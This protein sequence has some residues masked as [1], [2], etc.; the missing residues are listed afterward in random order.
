MV[1]D[2]DVSQFLIAGTNS[3]S[4]KTTLTLGIL[5]ALSRRGMRVAPFKCGPDYID[6]LFHKQAAGRDSLNLDL[7]FHSESCYAPAL[8]DAD[9]AVVEGVMGLFDGVSP[10]RIDGSCAEV[11][12]CLNLP[13]ILTVNA[14]GMSGSIAPLVKGFS[15]WHPKL[16]IAGVIANQVGSPRH[17]ELLK[18]SLREAGLPPLMG[19]LLRDERWTLPERHLGLTVHELSDD[20]LNLL[21]DTLESSLDL[22]QLLSLCRVT[23]PAAN[24]PAFPPARLRLGVAGDEAFCFY[25]RSNLDAL[26]R[27][28]VEPVF[29]SPLHDT[30]L[31]PG[32]H[33]LYL[34][35]GYPEL[36]LDELAAN[37]TMVNSIKA[38]AQHHLVYGECGGYLSLLDEIR[39]FSGILHPGLGL[40]PGRARMNRKLSALGYRTVSGDWGVVRG[41]EFHYSSL[42][43]PLSPPCLWT[44][45]DLRGNRIPCGGIRGRVRGSYVHLFFDS[46]NDFLSHFCRELQS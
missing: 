1:S 21:A 19:F 37:R 9:V 46:G 6:P 31:P 41:H 17:G 28:G 36:F 16:K 34:G 7:F 29:F 43:E 26:R 11:A 27:H 25:Y 24:I 14:Q 40:L 35:G 12:L 32:L 33:G 8:A 38:F 44:A 4:G 3:G 18:S 2:S 42:E 15:Q 5:R 45:E 30:C 39:D 13:V 23:H 20:W 10:G 22:D